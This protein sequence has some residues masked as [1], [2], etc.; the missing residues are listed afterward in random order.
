MVFNPFRRKERQDSGTYDN[1]NE[2]LI[3]LRQVTKNY[4]TA[5]GDFTALR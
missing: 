4:E 2:Q 3:E 1:G 5:A